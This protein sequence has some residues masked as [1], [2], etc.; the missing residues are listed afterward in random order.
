MRAA[1]RDAG[2]SAIQAAAVERDLEASLA[3]ER[4]VLL[5]A[6][7]RPPGSSKAGQSVREIAGGEGWVVLQEGVGHEH[8]RGCRGAP[9]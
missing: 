1:A 3:G 4:K 8:W 2:L 5:A 7:S 9:P 6:L